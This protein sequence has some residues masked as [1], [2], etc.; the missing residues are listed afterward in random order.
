MDG[1][2]VKRRNQRKRNRKGE[3]EREHGCARARV[4]RLSLKLPLHF[5]LV[6]ALVGTAQHKTRSL[7]FSSL[8]SLLSGREVYDKNRFLSGRQ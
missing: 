2:M 7:L 5:F 8:S 4:P 6:F 1:W 3:R